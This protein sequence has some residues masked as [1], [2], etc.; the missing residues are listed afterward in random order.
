[1]P[2]REE[3]ENW[4]SKLPLGSRN[5]FD[6][7]YSASSAKLF[8]VILRVLN[9]RAESEDVLQEVFVKIWHNAGRYQANGLSPMTWLITIARNAAIDRLRKRQSSDAQATGELT[10]ILAD[11]A[12]GPEALAVRASGREQ[13]LACL[14][15][16]EQNR[17]EAVRRVYLQ[18]ETYAELADHF[19]VPL[20]TMRTWLRRSLISLRECLSR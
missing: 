7:L 20:N 13:L 6:S 10:E 4:I 17:S 5:A 15:E 16:L 8:G 1:M 9:D 14:G 12:P 18:G 2:T 19:D 11:P 3:L